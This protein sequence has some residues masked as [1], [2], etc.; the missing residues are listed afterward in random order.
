[1]TISRAEKF[2]RKLAK[3]GA[4]KEGKALFEQLLREHR[5]LEAAVTAA[6]REAVRECSSIISAGEGDYYIPITLRAALTH[7][8][9]LGLGQSS[10]LLRAARW[11]V[12]CDS[13]RHMA[14]AI[15]IR[16]YLRHRTVEQIIDDFL[17]S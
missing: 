15:Q 2:R 11:L 12:R 1:M 10:D 6:R 16:S 3:R 7:N 9:N 17:E 4:C 13:G 14:S 8:G 5:T